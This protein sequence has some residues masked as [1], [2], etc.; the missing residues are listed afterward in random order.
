MAQTGAH[1]RV[2]A[3]SPQPWATF[4]VL[5]LLAALVTRN[6]SSK[7]MALPYDQRMEFR[8]DFANKLTVNIL[9]N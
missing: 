1:M 8:K 7:I 9:S 3:D 2:T 4:A 5:R 6:C